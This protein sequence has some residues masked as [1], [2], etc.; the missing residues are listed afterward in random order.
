M[1]SP[2]CKNISLDISGNQNYSFAVSRPHEGRIAIVT[3]RWARDAMDAAA[4]RRRRCASN[5]GFDGQRPAKPLGE[6]GLRTVKSCG[7]G[8][9]YAGA[10]SA[11]VRCRPTVT[12]SSLHREEH[13]VSRKAIAQGMSVC[14]PLTCMLVCAYVHFLAHE[15]AGAARTRHSLLPLFW[16]D[17]EIVTLGQIMS[18][19][20]SLIFT[21]R[22]REGGDPVFQRQ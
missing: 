2:F 7:S 10:R 16:R 8:V 11:A 4:P 12:T 3:T 21:R 5:G 1:S 15:T 14:S 20:R 13:E 6:A 9:A 22:P 18:R 19:E 17:N